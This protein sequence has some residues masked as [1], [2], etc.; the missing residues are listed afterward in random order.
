MTLPHKIL[1]LATVSLLMAVSAATVRG[2]TSTTVAITPGAPTLVTS[3]RV[4]VNN[5]PGNHTDPH[6][7][8]DLVS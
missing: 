1:S 2:Q 7:S 6:V 4:T 3:P 8:G 5:G